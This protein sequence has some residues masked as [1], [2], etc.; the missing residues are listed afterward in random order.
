MLFWILHLAQR[1]IV[2]L[3]SEPGFIADGH[4]ATDVL[5]DYQ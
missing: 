1:A 2:V 5:G 4:D 3:S